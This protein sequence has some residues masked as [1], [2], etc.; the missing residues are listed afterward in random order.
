MAGV[1]VVVRAVAAKEWLRSLRTCRDLAM[2]P[3]V[4]ERDPRGSEYTHPRPPINPRRRHRLRGCGP[5]ALRVRCL[6]GDQVLHGQLGR[7]GPSVTVRGERGGVRRFGTG[8]VRVRLVR[9]AGRSRLSEHPS[10]VWPR[11]PSATSKT[12]VPQFRSPVARLAG[13]GWDVLG[14]QPDRVRRRRPA[15]R[16]SSH[17]SGSRSGR[18][19]PC[20]PLPPPAART[21]ALP[22]VQRGVRRAREPAA[23]RSG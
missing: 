19:G 10:V 11:Q 6:D 23:C 12:R 18:T 5:Q 17:P 22:A 15:P 16:R 9:K 13:L 8:T 14:G 3:K 1:A 20:R 21:S 2:P 4:H 7:M